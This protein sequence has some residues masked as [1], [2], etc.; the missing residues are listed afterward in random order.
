MVDTSLYEV[1]M[2]HGMFL[3]CEVHHSGL[4]GR[5]FLGKVVVRFGIHQR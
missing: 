1:G 2:P 4:G 3:D 5:G